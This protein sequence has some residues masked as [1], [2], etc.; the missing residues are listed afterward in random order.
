MRI[1][2]FAWSHEP[3]RASQVRILDIKLYRSEGRVFPERLNPIER[4]LLNRA[5]VCVRRARPAV[6]D[7]LPRT[8]AI[9]RI[10]EK[11][12]AIVIHAVVSSDRSLFAHVPLKAGGACAG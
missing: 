5:V 12:S 3:G 8:R 7:D 6:S 9:R 11:L 10:H 2:G 1:L 4:R